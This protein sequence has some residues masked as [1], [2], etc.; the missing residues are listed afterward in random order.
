MSGGRGGAGKDGALYKE[1]RECLSWRVQQDHLVQLLMVNWKTMAKRGNTV[2]RSA[3]G[4][5]NSWFME[6]GL[7]SWTWIYKTICS[8]DRLFI[9]AWVLLWILLWL[10]KLMTGTWALQSLK[11]I[12]SISWKHFSNCLSNLPCHQDSWHRALHNGNQAPSLPWMGTA[13]ILQNKMLGSNLFPY[14]IFHVSY[15][16]WQLRVWHHLF[17]LKVNYFSP[18]TL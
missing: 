8:L 7:F 4:A 1:T 18:L 2:S 9:G 13:K 15:K 14:H 5:Q 11:V 12:P 3:A 16:V 6:Y 10:Y 17:L